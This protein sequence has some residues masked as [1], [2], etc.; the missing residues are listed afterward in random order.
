M[1]QRFVLCLAL[2]LVVFATSA[3]SCTG[4][5]SVREETRA[6]RDQQT[7]FLE[8]Q[9]V[10]T[11]EWSQLRQNLIELETAQA[12][13]TQT[14]TL[15][16]NMGSDMP[17][18]QCPSIGFPIAATYQLTNP[19][20]RIAEGAVVEQMESTGVYTADTTGTYAMCVSVSGAVYAV[21][22]EG[23]V[24][25]VTGAAEFRNG[26]VTLIGEPT[27]DFSVGQET[28]ATTEPQG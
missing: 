13:T 27:V 5:E 28:T 3:A 9:P 22:W 24:M 12:R 17:V 8:T 23:F 4:D 26:Q 15:F 16:F 20:Q 19:L 1:R 6:A 10:P 2:M 11:F 7:R 25:T 21:Y 18:A 14:T